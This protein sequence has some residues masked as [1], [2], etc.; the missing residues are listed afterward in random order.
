MTIILA[1]CKPKFIMKVLLFSFALL[2]SITT[3]S[4]ITFRNAIGN[5]DDDIGACVRETDDFGFI[6]AGTTGSVDN[7][8]SDIY[9][10]KLDSLGGLLWSNHFGTSYGTEN[11]KKVLQTIDKGYIIVGFTNSIGNG[12]YDAYVI[13]VDSIGQEVWSKTYGGPNWDFANDI[14][15]LPSANYGVVGSTY[16]FG[17]GG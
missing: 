12:G 9:L 17:N 10:F 14:I 15:L 6:V 5:S 4:Q 1:L 16:S 8:N 2:Y 7:T 3:F 11:G 13:K